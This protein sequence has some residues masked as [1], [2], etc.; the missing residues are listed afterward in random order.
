MTEYG[1]YNDIAPTN[2]PCLHPERLDTH[3]IRSLYR[4]AEYFPGG[5][6]KKIGSGYEPQDR[7]GHVVIGTVRA[8]CDEV[9]RLRAIVD[10][11]A[12]QNSGN[13]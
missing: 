8:L 13:R 6:E 5:V 2:D 10:E 1:K 4:Y 12:Q 9:D 3:G 11:Y 7:I